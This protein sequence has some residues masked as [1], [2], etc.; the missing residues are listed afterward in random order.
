MI[1]LT[2]AERQ[3]AKAQITSFFTGRAETLEE[4]EAENLLEEILRG[5]NDHQMLPASPVT[6]TLSVWD[7]QEILGFWPNRDLEPAAKPW[8]LIERKIA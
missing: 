3:R 7:W 5:V 2:P 8:S 6:V 1:H 4:F